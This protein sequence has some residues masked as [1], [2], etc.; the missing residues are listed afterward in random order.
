MPLPAIIIAIR[1]FTHLYL[2]DFGLAQTTEYQK[3][4]ASLSFANTS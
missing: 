4:D 2:I 1:P 3:L